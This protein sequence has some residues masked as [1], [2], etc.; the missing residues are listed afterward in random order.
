MYSS[1]LVEPKS[2]NEMVLFE[3]GIIE[4]SSLNEN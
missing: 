1:V 4:Q 3:E 2:E